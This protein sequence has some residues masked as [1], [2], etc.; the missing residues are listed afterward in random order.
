MFIDEIHKQLDPFDFVPWVGGDS[1]VCGS[2][3]PDVLGGNEGEI[4]L[5]FPRRGVGVFGN[6]GWIQKAG[7]MTRV[8]GS[9]GRIRNPFAGDSKA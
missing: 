9:V 7:E 3:P 4:H 2:A 8:L 6:R 5:G 1:G